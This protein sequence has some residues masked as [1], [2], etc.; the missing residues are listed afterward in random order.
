M[1]A[2]NSKAMLCVTNRLLKLI[3]EDECFKR[4]KG[5]I[6]EAK[7]RINMLPEQPLESI[8][9]PNH[10]PAV[11]TPRYPLTNMMDLTRR[12]FLSAVV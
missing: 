1:A 12:V 11:N 3:G 9:S 6:D 7:S 10:Y 8:V 4:L 2:K 5:M